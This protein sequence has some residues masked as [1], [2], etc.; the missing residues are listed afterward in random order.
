MQA[1]FISEILTEQQEAMLLLVANFL[2]LLALETP[3]YSGQKPPQARE[4]QYKAQEPTMAWFA[5]GSEMVQV[6]AVFQ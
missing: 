4:L 3:Q 6:W 1:A 2:Q 5:L